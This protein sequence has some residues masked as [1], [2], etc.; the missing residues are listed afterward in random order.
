MVTLFDANSGVLPAGKVK[1]PA[2]PAA[3]QGVPITVNGV[4]ISADAVR[5]EAQH[6]QADTP[7]EAF[8]Q[9]AQALV[10]KELLLQEAKASGI[11]A[12]PEVLGDGRCEAETDATVRVL[13]EQAVTTPTADE[14][15]C[16]RYYDTNASRFHS[17]TLYEA[18]HILFA[19]PQADEAA[20]K[21][22][23]SDAQTAIAI[24]NDDP[25]QFVAL[26]SLHSACPSK[27]QGGNLG[28]L[29]KGATVPEFEAALFALEA[30]ELAAT[31]VQTRY[32]YHIIKLDRLIPGRQ[33]S[34]ETQHE[35]I[36]AWL[37][38]ASWSRAVAQYLGIL[39][40]KAK[41]RGIDLNTADGPLTQ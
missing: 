16:R 31:P 6:H 18:R 41:L 13:L 20:G 38:A 19:F 23:Q 33:L 12:E 26:A 8:A 25:S 10:V 27:E 1:V 4:E 3:D 40:G 32:G 28:Q 35:R 9:A 22:A 29:T 21:Q 37:E 2:P 7:S 30:G 5:A 17:E 11:K 34:F 15:A 14:D 36:A 39:A 24:L